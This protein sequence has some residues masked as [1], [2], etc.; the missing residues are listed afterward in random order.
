MYAD[1]DEDD[2]NSY[3]NSNKYGNQHHQSSTSHSQL[4]PRDTVQYAE[5]D[6]YN[7]D[8]GD[9]EGNTSNLPYA[10]DDNYQQPARTTQHS[11]QSYEPQ[12][13][14]P[15]PRYMTRGELYG[16]L[17]LGAWLEDADRCCC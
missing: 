4:P 5:N 10:N 1:A 11:Q 13:Q 17:L 9:I 8:D 12:P 16:L 3:G 2:N 15:K 6:E 7:D 14:L